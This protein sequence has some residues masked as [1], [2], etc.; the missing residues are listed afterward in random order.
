MKIA[1]LWAIGIASLLA[2][3]GNEPP[4]GEPPVSAAA[5]EPV[6]VAEPAPAPA[7]P[8]YDEEFIEHM[9]THADRMDEMMFALDDG[10]LQAAMI[11]AYWLS[12]HNTVEGIPDEWQPFVTGM[13]EGARAVEEATDLESARTA[14]EGISVHCQGCHAAAGV[15]VTE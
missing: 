10:D 4:A 15:L 3:C 13:R 8:G 9:H 1:T 12:R 14:A 5:E 6:A 7:N 2:A 11:P